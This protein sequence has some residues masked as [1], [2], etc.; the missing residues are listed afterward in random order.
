MPAKHTDMGH[1]WK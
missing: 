1:W